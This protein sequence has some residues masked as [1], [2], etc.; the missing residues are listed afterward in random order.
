MIHFERLHEIVE[1][2]SPYR[3][4]GKVD[5]VVGLTIRVKSLYAFI[6]EICKIILPA[7]REIT[8]EVVGFQSD[9]V[10]L[11]PLG[12][13]DGIMTGCPVIPTGKALSV[14][15][16]S[17][18]LGQ[19]LDGLGN[20]LSEDAQALIHHE[21]EAQLY[22]SPPNPLTRPPI[23]DVMHTGVRAIDA[24]L[25]CGQGQRMGV[26][27]GSGVGKST[28]LGMISRYSDADVNVI[29]LIGE[30]GREVK[31]FLDKDLGPDGLKKSIVIC[32]T[33][34]QPPLVRLKGAFLATAVAEYFRDQGKNVMLMMD[35][36]TRFAMAQREVSLAA[37]EAPAT[38]G[39]TPSV[40]A[41]LPKL[42]ER[43]GTS[44]RGS[45]TAF[46]TVLV[47]G[48]DMN[49]PIADAVRG[50]L[51]GH[52][53]LSRELAAQSHYPAIDVPQSVS[54]LFHDLQGKAE[55]KQLSS[56]RHLMGAYKESE[57]LIQIGAYK[58]GTSPVIDRAVALKPALDAFLKQDIDEASSFDETLSKIQ[59]LYQ[60]HCG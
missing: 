60:K 44:A 27:A 5:Q 51:D 17:K 10:I 6:G 59:M 52:I 8:A 40:F 2:T 16:G 50:I 32:A 15:V 20:L 4:S 54:R 12:D 53:V 41:L 43:S 38:K 11:M 39:Y 49:E 55:V 23:K 36:V 31:A 19:V 18:M 9:N 42:L 33:S 7:G 13:L 22:K 34:D 29:A 26:F 45:I 46:Y 58:A 48:D 25:T 37:G 56:L 30:R 14:G 3:Y 47:E 21:H 1:T 24:F 57:D 35:S 28:L